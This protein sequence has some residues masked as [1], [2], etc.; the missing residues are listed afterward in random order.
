M[1]L[2]V[3]SLGSDTSQCNTPH[4]RYRSP[5][6]AWEAAQADYEHPLWL[7]QCP[8]CTYWRLTPKQPRDAGLPV[9][10]RKVVA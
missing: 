1:N 7:Y 4:Q 10:C 9:N 8:A 6:A 2:A 3:L 5:R